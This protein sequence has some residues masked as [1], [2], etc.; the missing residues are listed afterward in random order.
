MSSK[1]WTRKS[2]L[3]RLRRGAIT[4][5]DAAQILKVTE[6]QIRRL[7]AAFVPGDVIGVRHGNRGRSPSNRTPEGLRRQVLSLFADEFKGFNDTHF[8]ELLAEEKSIVMARST[9]QRI[10]RA[11]GHKAARKRRSQRYRCRR[12]RE[13]QKGRMLLWDGSHHDWLEGRGPK[14]SLMGAVDDAT[15]ELMPGAHFVPQESAAGYLR[16]LHDTVKEYGIP[17]AIY[18]DR[19]GSLKRN[20]G[21]WTLEEELKGE[22]TPTH[23]GQSLRELGIEVIYALSPQAK[24]RVER[25]WGTLQDRL[26]SEMRRKRIATVEDANTFVDV[27]RIRYNK[28]FGKQARES[29]SAWRSIPPKTVLEDV[30]AFRYEAV[31]SN[32]NLVSIDGVKLQIPRP[33]GGRSFAKATVQVRQRLSGLWRVFYKETCIAALHIDGVANEVRS[34]RKHKRS[35]STRAFMKAVKTYDAPNSK[36]KPKAQKSKRLSRPYNY[37]TKDEKIAAAKKS[38][39]AREQRPASW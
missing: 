15:G 3:E 37:W 22:Q 27:F 38:K 29:G 39:F 2:T 23:I 5:G 28:R 19:H 14:M 32:D 35:A 34:R 4:P 8:V 20:D 16:V 26:V 9:F 24:G 25:L 36:T 33:E 13:G 12:V 30:C 21:F 7:S 10:A 1:E 11:G 6:R 31:V 18:M 17:G